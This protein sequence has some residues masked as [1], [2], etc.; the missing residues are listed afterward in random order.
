ML[1]LLPVWRAWQATYETGVFPTLDSIRSLLGTK[2]DDR[3]AHLKGR[4]MRDIEARSSP[5]PPTRSA[6]LL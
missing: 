2:I 1:L 5:R 4:I 3:L 6:P